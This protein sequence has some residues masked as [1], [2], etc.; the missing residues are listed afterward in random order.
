M[1]GFLQIRLWGPQHPKIAHVIFPN[2]F[3]Y[4]IFVGI[5]RDDDPLLGA[6]TFFQSCLAVNSFFVSYLQVTIPASNV[7]VVLVI[8]AL[9]TV[10]LQQKSTCLTQLTLKRNVVQI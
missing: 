10:S 4:F 8:F 7:L 6:L 9:H 2:G 1:G 5:T 3:E